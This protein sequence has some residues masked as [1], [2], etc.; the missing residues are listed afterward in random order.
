MTIDDVVSSVKSLKLPEHS[1]VVFGSGPMAALKIREVNDVDLFV[2]TEV[3]EELKE[4]GW[5]QITKGPGDEPFVKDDCEAH[6]NW[7]FSPYAPSLGELLS[8]AFVIDGV[9]FASIEDVRKWKAASG[10]AK[11]EADVQ[12][13]DDYLAGQKTIQEVV[14]VW[15]RYL[16]TVDNWESLV[17]GIEPKTG[18]CG[19]VYEVPNPIDRP[20]ES[21]AIADMRQLELSDPH[22]HINGESEIYFVLQGEGKMTVGSE[23]YELTSGTSIVTPP[24]TLHVTLPSKDLVLAVVNTPPFNLDNCVMVSADDEAAAKAIAKLRGDL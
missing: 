8:R 24:D 21:F 15:T 11:H 18:G 17:E 4:A 9:A 22:K 7:N 6:A 20:N 13:I 16:T 5:Q 19:L 3:L 2:S 12:R 14:D 23:L 1:Y 10:G